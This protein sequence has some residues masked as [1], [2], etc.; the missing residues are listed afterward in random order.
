MAPLRTTLRARLTLLYVSLLCVVLVLYAASTS[1]FLWQGLLRELDLSLDRDLETVENLIALTPD[2]HIAANTG[3]QEG[4]LLLEV[5]SADG[6]LLY[7]SENLK[8]QLLG[9]A[10]KKHDPSHPAN[11]S[12]RLAT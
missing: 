2:G 11:Y 8:G 5:W 6:A 3:D 10:V 7:Q 12:V 4:V 9:A 1:I